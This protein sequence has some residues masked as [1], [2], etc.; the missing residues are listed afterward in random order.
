MN[1]VRIPVEDVFVDQDGEPWTMQHNG[2]LVALN[3]LGVLIHTLKHGPVKNGAEIFPVYEIR[4]RL[5]SAAGRDTFELTI[6]QHQWLMKHLQ[7][8]CFNIWLAPSMA[9][10]INYLKTTAVK[11]EEEANNVND[12][13]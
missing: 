7:N 1:T 8:N 5:K 11:T 3:L 10:L 12:N 2:D 9:Y 6:N 13:V 4:E